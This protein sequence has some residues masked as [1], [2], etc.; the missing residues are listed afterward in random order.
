MKQIL[1]PSHSFSSL[2]LILI[3]LDFCSCSNSGFKLAEQS[4][5]KILGNDQ[6]LNFA[7]AELE[8]FL[9]K[10]DSS[11]SGSNQ[12]VNCQ[13]EFILRVDTI[14]KPYSFKVVSKILDKRQI[15]ELSGPNPTCVLH[16][17]Y[18]MLEQ[19]GFQFEMSGSIVKSSGI[20]LDKLDNWTAE[21]NPSVKNRGIRQHIN[22]PMD[23]SSYSLNDAKEYI[24]NVAR[25]RFNSISFHSYNNQWIETPLAG[26][27]F[28]GER[29]DL[30]ADTLIT[31]HINNIKTF[32]IPELEPYFDQPEELSKRSIAW[33][34]E[35]MKECKSV[36]LLIQFSFE[37]YTVSKDVN[38]VMQQ[39]DKI[40]KN[41][42]LIDNLEL[43]TSES[44]SGGENVKNDEN[45]KFIAENIGTEILN[46]EAIQTALTKE[47][48][49]TFNNVL[50]E[51]WHINNCIIAFKKNHNIP[52]SFGVYC[53]SPEIVDA[54]MSIMRKIA[55]ADVHFAILAEHGAQ[56]VTNSL[57]KIKF[58]AAD[59]QRTM[60]YSWIE[61]DGI[62]YLQQ[63]CLTGIRAM[64]DDARKTM[65]DEPLYGVCFNHWRTEENRTTGRYSS[66]VTLN[67]K[68]NEVEFYKEYAK[69]LG[70]GDAVK[71]AEAMQLLNN[72]DTRSGIEL[73][74]LG[75]CFLPCWTWYW[76]G[77]PGLENLGYFGMWEPTILKKSQ[78]DYDKSRGLLKIC[79]DKTNSAGGRRYLLFLENR[80][81]ATSLYIDAMYK[82]TEIQP[83]FLN[84]NPSSFTD[85]DRDKI[86]KVCNESKQLFRKYLEVWTQSMP[87]RGCEGT[88]ISAYITIPGYCDN[89]INKYCN[90]MNIDKKNAGADTPPSPIQPK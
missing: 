22:F 25:M 64:F 80:L 84:R 27:F 82:G 26:K 50:N 10:A 72:A 83:V 57:L 19:M 44:F 54:S 16:A 20:Q 62:M 81:L 60:V 3:I 70:I 24:R 38:V 15:V 33:L 69:N 1:C 77:K 48:N 49:I 67:T 86:Q 36:G 75:F 85:Q 51:V 29:H 12:K 21:I 13:W 7:K 59:W 73:P 58:T 90:N 66:E 47:N 18:T 9:L 31:N 89:L 71:Y 28:Y 6:V 56:A 23:I 4:E 87:D 74:N 88:L 14:M 35:V 42:P 5:I 68:L 2:I 34:Q 63:N 46:D 79:L 61:F 45:R 52:M 65:N 30:P 41:Y 40:L 76:G 8:K 39:C 32:C 78:A 55:P 43:I 11:L 37:P 17:M 53:I